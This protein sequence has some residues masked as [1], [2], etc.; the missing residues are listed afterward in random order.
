MQATLPVPGPRGVID[1]ITPYAYRM[2][3]LH[4]PRRFGTG[5]F[6]VLAHLVLVAALLHHANRPRIEDTGPV[7]YMSYIV[8]PTPAAPTV[9]ER[10]ASITPPPVRRSRPPAARLEAQPAMTIVSP[11]EAPAVPAPAEGTAP[12]TSPSP[13]LDMVALRADARRAGKDYEPEPFEQVRAA[14]SR[15]EAEKKDLGRAI[16]NTKR[17][18]CTKKYS[19]GEK[20]NLIALIP[21]AIDTITDTGCKW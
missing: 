5:L 14:E 6:I 21:L 8:V 13:K 9:E 19:G 16:A 7:E 11:A 4:M 20:L 18:P 3:Q 1:T 2:L 12:S 15:L 10:T 17:P